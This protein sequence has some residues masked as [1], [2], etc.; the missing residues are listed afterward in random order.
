MPDSSLTRLKIN[1]RSG[2]EPVHEDG[3]PVGFDVLDFW[4]WYTSDLVTN[5][6][7]GVLAEYIVA[8]ALGVPTSGVREA[9]RAFD[10]Q[11]EDG[12][13]IEV[14]SA[15]YVQSWSQKIL[16]PIQFVVQKSLGWDA[17]TGV[18]ETEARRQADVYVFALLACQDKAAVDP[19]NLAQWQFWAVATAT[20]DA[21]TRSQQSITLKSLY[22]LAGDPVGFR[23]LAAAVRRAA[24]GG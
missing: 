10:L 21:R 17:D 20:L 19:L 3:Q 5:T 12:L 6:T 14:K 13:R 1:R 15:A 9:W 23:G 2:A 11:T 8:R 22:K 7:R 18:M 4:G 24:A 16:S